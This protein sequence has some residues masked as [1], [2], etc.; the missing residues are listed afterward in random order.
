MKIKHYLFF[1]LSSVLNIFSAAKK[2]TVGGQAIIEGVMMRGKNKISWAVRKGPNDVVIEHEEFVSIAH[3]YPILKK[4]IL[5]GAISLYESLVIGYKALSRSAE[6]TTEAETLQNP[7]HIE[8]KSNKVLEKFYSILSFVIALAISMGLFMYAPMWILSK[9]IPKDSALL[10]NALAGVM[11]ITLFLGYLTLISMWKEI[12]RVFEYHGAE[13]KAI[14]TFE[15]GK[16]LTT[17]NMQPYST[18]HPRC[19]TSFY[20]L[21]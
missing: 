6:I 14:F 15:D 20:F 13:H 4:P 10:F 5:R 12:R 17:A 16:E 21:S 2:N 1:I 7:G 19:G 8:K 3:K 11:R 9:F 18:F